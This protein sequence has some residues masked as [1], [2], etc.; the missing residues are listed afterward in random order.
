MCRNMYALSLFSKSSSNL[1]L[2]DS[3]PTSGTRLNQWPSESIPFTSFRLVSTDQ[4]GNEID[5]DSFI[6]R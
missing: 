2:L 4:I 1:W 5:Y 3:P 6:F